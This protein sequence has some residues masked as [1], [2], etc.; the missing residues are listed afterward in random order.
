MRVRWPRRSTLT[1][2]SLWALLWG[3]LSAGAQPLVVLDPGHGGHDPGAG[4]CGNQEAAVVL[5]IGRRLK[6]L[7]ASTGARVAMTRESDVFVGLQE[8]AAFANSRGATIFVSLHIN[9]ATATAT[10]SE[11]WISRSASNASL[12]LATRM[13]RSLVEAWGLA[14]RGVK[15]ENFTV[16][17]NTT[18]PACL[19]E[20][21]FINNCGRDSA[22][23]SDANQRQKIAESEARGIADHLNLRA[24]DPGTQPGGSTGR[25]LGVV[26]EDRG[27]GLDDT[28]VRL[29]GVRVAAT[30][31]NHSMNSE[32]GTGAWRFDLPPG[33]YRVVG[34]LNGFQEG[35]R[36]CTVQA[37]IDNWCSFGL[38]RGQP[39][40]QPEPD[41]GVPQPELD[42]EV[43]LEPAQDA[44]APPEPELDAEVPLE[45]A[46]DAGQPPAREEDADVY[47]PDFG[48]PPS[49]ADA[50]SEG[51]RPRPPGPA[52]QRP[53]L[54]TDGDQ[55][56]GC[57]CSQLD[58]GPSNPWSLA[59]LALLGLRLR[60]R[61]SLRGA[62]SLA[63]TV[64]LLSVAG[65]AGWATRAH[66][67][68]GAE[69]P[70]LG[71]EEPL[72]S[73]DFA[74]VVPSPDGQRLL[75]I[76][77]DHRTLSWVPTAGGQDP[78]E[79]VRGLGVGRNPLWLPD[80]SGVAVRTPDQSMQAIPILFYD[81]RGQERLPDARAFRAPR[82]RIIDDRAVWQAS[83]LSF[84]APQGPKGE[85]FI[86]A[87]ESAD[88]RHAVLWGMQT[89]L[90]LY[91]VETQRLRN[92][93]SGS[94]PRF[95]V[96]GE[97]LVFE[98]TTDDGHRLTSGDLLWLDL[99]TPGAQAV[100]LTESADRIEL[101]PA[102]VGEQLFFIVKGTLY[103]APLRE[104]AGR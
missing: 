30:P 66:A 16:I 48:P 17:T 49:G 84:P 80:S 46:Q 60:R 3:P 39:P 63:A 2:L 22:L 40:V 6:P 74:E 70:S 72:F 67:Q 104:R 85:R 38:R 55:E 90:W 47:F 99:T 43:P 8:R 35:A 98:R 50:G 61:R 56:G 75:L 73:G 23:M 87:R 76:S 21:G 25:L 12:T 78:I 58:A 82:M 1:L 59:L 79:I 7:V 14:D 68:P 69:G 92:L 97:A 27:A 88:G 41:A 51:V 9:S 24:P 83:P 5:D 53:T 36:T 11:T 95:G 31:G 29:A 81:L 62:L 96:R 93:G 13:Q 34:T 54:P 77:Q 65:L 37:N 101:S 28:S 71:A 42:A 15:R 20:H 45:P 102:L 91:E 10:G 52:P 94:H 18:M 57:D 26:F 103:R 19:L 89:G 4:A 64:G 32:G 44:E 86:Y 100:P 33:E